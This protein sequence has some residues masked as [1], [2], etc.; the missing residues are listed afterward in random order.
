[1]STPGHHSLPSHRHDRA[2]SAITVTDDPADTRNR[3]LSA[4]AKLFSAHGFRATTI[5]AIAEIVGILS[6]SLFHYF[7][8]KREMLFEVMLQ[9]AQSMCEQ[10]DTVAASAA[11]PR[12]R[13]GALI[14]LQLECLAGEH[15][16]D[17]YAVLI[18]E[19]REL[20]A[21]SKPRLTE[22]RRRYFAAW[23]RV[24]EDCACQG[25]LRAEPEATQLAL[26]GAINWANTWYR[27]TG[28]LSLAQY[29]AILEGLVLER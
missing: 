24:L 16:K 14:R 15:T 2:S 26:H 18:C 20:D 9:A 17:F 28:R 7:A 19:W 6:G 11:T 23:H 27:P 29:G 22:L 10:A 12:E 3:I 8:S 13:L 5:R 21:R 1:M 25:L 4:C